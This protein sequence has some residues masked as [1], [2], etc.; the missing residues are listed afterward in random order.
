MLHKLNHHRQRHAVHRKKVPELL[1]RPPHPCGLGRRSSSHDEWAGG[2]CQRYDSA[3]AQ[4]K[5]LQRPKQVRQ[6]VDERA[7]LG[8]LESEDDAE[9]RHEFYAVLSSLW[10]RGRPPHGL[11]IWLPEDQGVRRS[12]QPDQPRRRAVPTRGGSRRRLT[13]FGTVPAVAVTLPRPKHSGP[14]LP[15][16]RL[17]ASPATGCPRAS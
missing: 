12:K 10:G 11:R 14:R 2:A 6:A 7:T 1:R 8:S 17:G 9:P 4:T 16:G 5:D 15:S 3:G 13:T